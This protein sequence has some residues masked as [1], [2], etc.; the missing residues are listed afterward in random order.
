M[1]SHR[2]CCKILGAEACAS[3]DDFSCV[4]QSEKTLQAK[5][6]RPGAM[7][8]TESPVKLEQNLFLRFKTAQHRWTNMLIVRRQG[9]KQWRRK[10]VRSISPHIHRHIQSLRILQGP[11]THCRHRRQHPHL[12]RHHHSPPLRH[13]WCARPQAALLAEPRAGCGDSNR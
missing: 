2:N 9:N 11:S 7:T 5:L 10:C 12:P 13:H 1:T 6:W 4:R 8:G 3:R